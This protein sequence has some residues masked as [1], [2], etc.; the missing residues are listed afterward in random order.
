MENQ[1]IG[2]WAGMTSGG[3]PVPLRLQFHAD[4]SY[5]AT[6]TPQSGAQETVH[7]T[8]RLLPD[9]QVEATLAVSPTPGAPPL[10]ERLRYTR[11]GSTLIL[12]D[13]HQGDMTLVQVLT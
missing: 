1:L 8:Y 3:E 2:T 13:Q 11:A 5:S 6:Q 4:G 12:H 9:S 10:T 7:G